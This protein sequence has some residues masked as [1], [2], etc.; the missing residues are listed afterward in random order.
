MRQVPLGHLDIH[1]SQAGLGTVKFGRNQKIHYPSSFDLPTDQDILH[2]LGHAKELGI[3]L[4]DT[5]PAYGSSEERLGKLLKNQR[6]DWIICSK[7]GEEFIE[8]ESRYDFSPSFIQKSVERSLRRLNTDYLD[9]LLIHSNGEDEKII[10]EDGALE[11]LNSLKKAGL[12]RATGMSTKTIQGGLLAVEQSD[13]V[14]VTYNPFSPEEKPVI[15]HA[16]QHNKAI[17]IKK[18]LASGHLEKLGSNDPVQHAMDFIFQEAGVTSVILGT[19][20]KAHLTHNIQ[21]INQC[22]LHQ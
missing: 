21:C 5:A 16:H 1:V 10:L 4:L 6:H 19:L 7:A 12:I 22:S 15:Q 13:V 3:N 8:G 17:F 11:T 9:I 20:N 14:M 2:L 18:A